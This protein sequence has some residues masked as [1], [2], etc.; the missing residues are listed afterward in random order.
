MEGM[1]APDGVVLVGH[2]GV[3]RDCPRELV[4]RLKALEASRRA[5][6]GPA[7]EEEQALDERIR[8]WPRTPATD[9]YGAGIARVAEALRPLLGGAELVVAFNEFCAPTI[10]EAVEG[11]VEGGR[12]RI[13]VVPSMLTPGGVH[14]EVDIPEALAAL[15]ARHPGVDLRYAWPFDLE[16]VARLLADH[17]LGAGG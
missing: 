10:A 6:G 9:P 12:R 14:S 8:R 1:S 3:P 16:R 7:T 15:R 11:L 13:A 17:A 4:R 2:G 5:S